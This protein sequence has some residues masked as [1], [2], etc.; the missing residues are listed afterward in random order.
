[1]TKLLPRKTGVAWALAAL[2]LTT[3]WYASPVLAAD[4]MV[5]GELFGYSG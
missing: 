5:I 3:A 4:R 1:M 2:A